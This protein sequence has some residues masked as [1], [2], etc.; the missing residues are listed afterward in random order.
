MKKSL[1]FVSTGLLVTTLFM[2][3]VVS[4]AAMNLGN[5]WLENFG[6]QAGY[7]TRTLPVVIGGIINVVLGLMGLAA[8]III[9][10]GGFMWMTSGGSEEKVK[11]AKSLMGYAIMGLI[12]VLIAYAA[13]AFII[14]KLTGVTG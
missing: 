7:G 9:I 4:A 6:T 8:V 14:D 3:L 11:K 12:I 10:I 5:A 2:P 13:A 1:L